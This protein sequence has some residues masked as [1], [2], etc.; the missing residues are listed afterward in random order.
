ME[1]LGRTL[2]VLEAALD[3]GPYFFGDRLTVCDFCLVLQAVW[4]EIYPGTIGD[5]PNLK[6]LVERVS[7]RPAVRRVLAQHGYVVSDEG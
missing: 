3:P 1:R 7:D 4:P 6:R 5:Y 2:Q